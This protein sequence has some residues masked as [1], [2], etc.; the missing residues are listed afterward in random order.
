MPK[1]STT[2]AIT[3]FLERR[4]ADS[5]F[6][7]PKWS[8]DLETQVLTTTDGDTDPDHPGWFFGEDGEKWKNIR[9]P[10][11]AGNDPHYTD[12]PITFDTTKRI[13]RVGTTWWN[14]REKKS[15]AV[16]ID[17]DFDGEKVG[18]K[19]TND[20]RDIEEIVRR[21]KELDYVTIVRSTGGNGLHVYVFFHNCPSSDN[22]HEHTIVARKTLELISQDINYDLK[23]HVD[24]VGMVFWIWAASSPEGHPG[25]S[26]IKEGTTLDGSRLATVSL[27]TPAVRSQSGA[28]FE[29]VELDEE[30][31]RVLEAISRQ[32]F[33]FNIRADMNLIH[34][35][36]CAIKRAVDQLAEQGEPIV[37]GFTTAS[38]GTDPQTA[39]CFLA[40]LRGGSFRV[41]R[42]GQS[43]H[44]PDWEY[45][46]GK[47]FCYLNDDLSL[48]EMVS[49]QAIKYSAGKYYLDQD[50][51]VEL[52]ES[53][54]EPFVGDVPDD[55]T[56]VPKGDDE[57]HLYSKKAEPG[58][59]GWEKSGKDTFRK[60]IK[61]KKKTGSFKD[62]ILRMC[63]S[64]IRFVIQNGQPRGWYHKIHD[65]QWLLHR[66]YSELSC[67]VKGQFGEFADKAHQLMME[68]PWEMVQIPFMEEY[69]GDRQWNY[70]AP[71]LAVDPATSGGDHPHYDAI[72][73]HIGGD[74]DLP[75]QSN[76]WCR[77]AGIHTGADYLRAWLACLINHTQQPLPYLFLVGPQNSG[78]SIF[79][80]MTKFLFSHG[81]TSANLALTSQFNGELDG[82]FLVYVEERDLGDKKYNAYEKIKE[83][84]TGR[85]L[86][87]REMYQPPRLTPNY[88][89]FV[90]MANN[91]THLPLEDG[92]TRIVALDVPSL[93]NP[94]PKAVMERHLAEEAPRFLR[95][96]LNT[97][98]PAP[99]DRLRIPAIKTLSKEMME[100]RAMSPLM[101]FA[102]ERVFP[103]TGHKIPIGEFYTEYKSYCKVNG[104]TP[105]P[106]IVVQQELM[107]RSDRFEFGCRGETGYLLNVTFDKKAKPKKTPLS[108]NQNGRF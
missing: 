70:N 3:R 55:I 78:K 7:L 83:W 60:I 99:V 91:S 73:D 63:D 37:G 92:D 48:Q 50:G 87:V 38:D 81:V 77:K 39:N 88:L 4:R 45:Q 26:V 59:D 1:T 103:C 43:Q 82:C 62:R 47:N 68:N 42:F 32:P 23:T 52:A 69:P 102:R 85:D 79:H 12:P 72:L 11:S 54:G 51:A 94:I 95:T 86:Q 71:Q 98:V 14:W 90:Q 89:H 17:I 49:R 31:K 100:Q 46:D 106:Q 104:K 33:Y 76:E 9:W 64:Q 28:N 25:F 6:L 44:E 53:L 8:S 35:H 65:G 29:T 36:T 66:S 20:A 80:E 16:G 19:Q 2:Q 97:V 58:T 96:L 107:L 27:P 18:A 5:P 75:I 61:V 30:H 13:N 57:V 67:V 41:H 22:H 74:L 56:A 101:A 15:V 34:A 93:K 10:Y 21:L 108:V 40:P 105:D 24:C 84:V